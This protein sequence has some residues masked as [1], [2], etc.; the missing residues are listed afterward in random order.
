MI[1]GSVMC[2]AR[3]PPRPTC[4]IGTPEAGMRA[5]GAG[6]AGS[7]TSLAIFVPSRIVRQRDGVVTP[8]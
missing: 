3:A 5:P 4:N 8:L 6:S 2:E 7:I 1:I